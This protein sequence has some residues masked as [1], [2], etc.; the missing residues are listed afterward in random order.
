MEER[1][2]GNAPSGPKAARAA[3]KANSPDQPRDNSEPT[4]AESVAVPEPLD[5]KPQRRSVE[6]DAA[7]AELQARI[8]DLER[9][10]SEGILGRGGKPG[11]NADDAARKLDSSGKKL[12]L[13]LKINV[14]NTYVLVFFFLFFAP[15]TLQ[16]CSP[17]DVLLTR[18]AG[19]SFFLLQL[20]GRASAAL[21]V[22][23]HRH[24]NRPA[25]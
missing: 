19:S 6:A 3:A 2:L 14:P 25:R 23:R 5:R 18:R 11:D 17:N 21:A 1:G 20:P 16:P 4:S 15:S 24:Y 13:K 7:I 22:R 8:A 10:V 12:F 9:T